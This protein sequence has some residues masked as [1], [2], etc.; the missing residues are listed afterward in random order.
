[1]A[2]EGVGAGN[3]FP[4]FQRG[5]TS[6]PHIGYLVMDHFFVNG[7]FVALCVMAILAVGHCGT[8]SVVNSPCGLLRF[9]RGLDNSVIVHLTWMF[10]SFSLSSRETVKIL[11]K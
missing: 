9:A 2:T 5:S 8:L 6:M 4:Q 10:A 11:A 7:A 1:M 3:S